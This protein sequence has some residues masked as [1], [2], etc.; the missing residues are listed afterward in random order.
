MTEP[1]SRRD[2]IKTVGAVSAGALV[3]LDTSLGAPTAS[4]RVATAPLAVREVYA[5]R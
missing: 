4:P 1:Y 3:P 5:P 2:W